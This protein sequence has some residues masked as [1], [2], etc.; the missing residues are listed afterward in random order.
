[1]TLIALIILSNHLQ[2]V[3]T[4]CNRLPKHRAG[5]GIKAGIPSYPAG[6]IQASSHL[7]CT[8]RPSP[9]SRFPIPDSRISPVT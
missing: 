7:I 1:M 8:F 4:I 6:T 3:R 5:I 9:E 2:F